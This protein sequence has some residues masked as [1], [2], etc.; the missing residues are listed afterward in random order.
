MKTRL[1]KA[2]DNY[3]SNYDMNVR[4][5]NFKYYHSYRVKDLMKKLAIDLNLSK[6]EIE[7]AEV[8]GLLHDIGR[9][10]QIRKYGEC[11]DVRTGIDHADESCIY[12]FDEGHIKDFYDDE[13]YYEIIK[14]AIKNHN[15]YIIDKKLCGKNLLFTKMIRDTDKIDIY[16]VLSEEYTYTYDIKEINKEVLDTFNKKKTIDTHMKITKTDT[17]YTYFAFVYDI[18]FKESFKILKNGKY[19]E[20]LISVIIPTEESVEEFEKLK[21]KVSNYINKKAA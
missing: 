10:E 6:K 2:F 20:D 15:K 13:K 21:E 8:I 12:L 3:V 9:F 17:V 19:L 7:V 11:S 16:K 4:Q 14:D 18:N 5:I 1:E